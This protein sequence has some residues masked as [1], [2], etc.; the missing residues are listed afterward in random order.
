MRGAIGGCCRAPARR[1]MRTNG[2][3]TVGGRL[4]P[5]IDAERANARL[6]ILGPAIIQAGIPPDADEK[7]RQY[8]LHA[9][10]KVTPM[11]NGMSVTRDLYGEAMKLMIL[12]AG[13]VLAIAC[14]NLANLMHA[15]FTAR[16]REFATRLALGGASRSRLVQQAL[17]ESLVLSVIGAAL[18]LAI[19]RWG[20]ALLASEICISYSGADAQFLYLPFDARFFF[21]SPR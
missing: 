17:T 8:A 9:N 6:A 1:S 16:Q 3:L 21:G 12:M 14:A 13:I 7:L 10:L 19:A 20:G 4:K 11:P 18:G 2:S 15:R 5:G